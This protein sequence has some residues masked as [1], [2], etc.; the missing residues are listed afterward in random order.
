MG[1]DDAQD[2]SFLH[3]T[4]LLGRQ[5]VSTGDLACRCSDLGCRPTPERSVLERLL[6]G[7]CAVEDV[8]PIADLIDVDQA[9]RLG[10]KPDGITCVIAGARCFATAKEEWPPA[11]DLDQALQRLRP[12]QTPEI[13][14]MREVTDW[15]T[16]RASSSM[17]WPITTGT[18]DSLRATAAAS[19]RCPSRQR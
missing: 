8:D 7:W 11:G 10:D 18:D 19:L 6:Q 15:K 16:N 14:P 5:G 17:L 12:V 2:E 13:R 3:G 9:G 4:G 1:G